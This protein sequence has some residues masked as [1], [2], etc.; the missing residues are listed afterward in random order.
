M[1]DAFSHFYVACP[2]HF[3][4]P[5]PWFSHFSKHGWHSRVLQRNETNKIYKKEICCEE[6]IY[7]I[8]EDEK[9]YNLLSASRRPGKPVVLFQFLPK[10][11]RT[12]KPLCNFQSSPKAS[13]KCSSSRNTL[14]EIIFINHLSI[15]WFSQ[16][17][18]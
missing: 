16:V 8:M 18:M 3:Y 13:V 4:G 12:R 17:D 15:P 9:L 2:P 1:T 6:L 11:L 5:F 7:I 10:G 14:T